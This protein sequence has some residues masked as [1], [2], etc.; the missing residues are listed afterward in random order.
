MEK[1]SSICVQTNFH[2]KFK[3]LK[4]IGRGSFATVYLV[5][6][7]ESKQKYAV[8]AFHKEQVCKQ[9]KGKDALV[10]EIDMMRRLNHRFIMRLDEV[11][12]TGNSIYLVL[13]MLEGGELFNCVS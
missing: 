13:E 3:A 10:N 6:N 12:E 8:K 4:I 5:E 9:P 1:L 2:G 7:K 11:H